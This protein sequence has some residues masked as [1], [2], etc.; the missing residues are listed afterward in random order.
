MEN[1]NICQFNTFKSSDLVCSRFVYEC[2]DQQSREV[3]ADSDG[4]YLT[5]KG[6]GSVCVEG[7]TYPLRVGTLFFIR[8]QERF[9]V[10]S[11]HDL[12]YC[13]I[14]FGG[15]RAQEILSRFGIYAEHRLFQRDETLV[16]FWMNAVQ[17]AKEHNIDLMSEAVL[18][19]TMCGFD[20]PVKAQGDIVSRI[21]DLTEQNFADK[22]LSVASLAEEL[23]YNAKYL[24]SSFK[25]QMGISY[26][27]YLRNLRIKR[28]VFL[29][30]QGVA[31]VKNVAIL[32][33]F[34]DALYFSKVFK[35]AEGITPSEYIK[36]LAEQSS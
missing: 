3:V 27:E 11:E 30:E 26:V 16:A 22:K 2:T 19:Y 24:S 33:G 34:E 23:N 15:R 10:V 25:K 13:Y 20:A 12:G 7:N 17:S 29:M 18:L 9:S 31:S 5:V 4:I 28:A 1:R 21:L 6:T 35:Q 32:S 14:C 36:N 8:K